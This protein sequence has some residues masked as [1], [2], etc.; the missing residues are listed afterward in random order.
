MARTYRLGWWW[1]VG[2]G[3]VLLGL[4]AGC[5]DEVATFGAGGASGSGTG[6]A[7]AGGSSS[8]TGGSGGGGYTLDTLCE[9]LAPLICAGRQ[10][11]C[12]A[13]EIGFDVA[14]CE[15]HELDQCQANVS[16][17]EAGTMVFDPSQVDP[18][19]AAI[20]PF[21]DM[22]FV[23]VAD[24][25]AMIE[26]RQTCRA[27]FVGTAQLGEPCERHAQC[28][29]APSSEDITFCDGDSGQCALTDLLASGETCTIGGPMVLC[30][31]GLYCDAEIAGQPPFSGDCATATAPGQPCA[32]GTQPPSFE[33]GM[34]YLCSPATGSCELAKEPG[35]PCTRPFECRSFECTPDQVCGRLEVVIDE[36]ACLG[37]P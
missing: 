14:G 26:A 36:Q 17:V 35:E 31:S 21:L 33:C 11:C 25:L 24:R 5:G 27:I 18:C 32:A 9:E 20:Q 10:D 37:T 6:G 34:G 12:V 19:L 22:C 23:G 15:A 16:D 7:G 13:S 8:G 4:P 28:A 3:T 1:V 30:A 29:A 2:G